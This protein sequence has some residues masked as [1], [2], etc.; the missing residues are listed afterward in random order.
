[1]NTKLPETLR[2][3]LPVILAFSMAGCGNNVAAVTPPVDDPIPVQV[4]PVT[5]GDHNRILQY[6]GLIASNSEAHL[7][8]KIGGII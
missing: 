7:S 1:M 6:S 2:Y 4:Q 5:T 8:F 3:L